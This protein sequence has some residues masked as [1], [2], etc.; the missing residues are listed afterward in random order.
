[1]NFVRHLYRAQARPLNL[2]LK[3]QIPTK[4]FS[5]STRETPDSN[6]SRASE[7]MGGQNSE[8]VRDFFKKTDLIFSDHQ[9]LKLRGDAGNAK[10]L[11][12]NLQNYSIGSCFVGCSLIGTGVAYWAGVAIL[13]TGVLATLQRNIMLA[14]LATVVEKMQLMKDQEAIRIWLGG[15]PNYIQCRIEDIQLKK[16]ENRSKKPVT[17]GSTEDSENKQSEISYLAVIRTV[18]EGKAGAQEQ[19]FM[20]SIDPQT[21]DIPN[22]VL[23]N[24]VIRGDVEMVQNFRFEK[25][26]VGEPSEQ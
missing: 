7:D 13:T 16:F 8:S 11:L 26:Q 21:V 12:S 15:M 3:P 4:Y 14:S 2:H 19:D 24:F 23:L 17:D 20:V 5:Q 6:E 9:I 22:L 18:E 25:I 1:M 10:G